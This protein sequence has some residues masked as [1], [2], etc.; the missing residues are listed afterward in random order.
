MIIRKKNT[1]RCICSQAT[2][3]GDFMQSAKFLA[4]T[5]QNVHEEQAVSPPSKRT[6]KCYASVSLSSDMQKRKCQAERASNILRHVLILSAGLTSLAGGHILN[7]AYGTCAC[8]KCKSSLLCR[9]IYYSILLV[10]TDFCFCHHQTAET[11]RC[12]MDSWAITTLYCLQLIKQGLKPLTL[13][14]I[15]GVIHMDLTRNKSNLW[16]IQSMSYSFPL[17]GFRDKR[18]LVVKWVWVYGLSQRIH[19]ST[20]V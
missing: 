2:L 16:V 10:L 14:W 18:N 11:R 6:S 5:Q 3:L 7:H 1:F 15:F 17:T 12:L 9:G 4:D 8:L 19:K 20:T 13:I